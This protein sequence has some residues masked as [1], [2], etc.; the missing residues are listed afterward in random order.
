MLKLLREGQV[1]VQAG[2]RQNMGGVSPKPQ[3]LTPMPE[4]P[5]PPQYGLTPAAIHQGKYF[6]SWCNIILNTN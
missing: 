1:F 4:F 3:N 2:K 5:S 6:T